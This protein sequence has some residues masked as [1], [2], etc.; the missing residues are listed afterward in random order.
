VPA[1]IAF[2]LVAIGVMLFSIVSDTLIWKRRLAG[3]ELIM[4]AL[5]A[6]SVVL[7]NL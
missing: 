7:L 3:R 6:L 5:L 1:V 2:P 4:Y